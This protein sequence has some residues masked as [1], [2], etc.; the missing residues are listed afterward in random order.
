MLQADDKDGHD[1]KP[2]ITK[3]YVKSTYYSDDDDYENYEYQ[4]RDEFKKKKYS[5]LERKYQK[6][7][8]IKYDDEYL[9]SD[10][11]DG[12]LLTGSD[13][14]EKIPDYLREKNNQSNE[15][16]ED[17][18]KKYPPSL[19][20]IVQ[21]T[22]LNKIKVGTLYIITFKGG[23]LGREGDHDVVIPDINIS[24]FHLKFTY[25]EK[26]SVYQCIDLGSR[27][28][29]ILN[30]KRMSTAKQ[31]SELMD[32]VHG[33]T[34]QLSQTKLLCHIHPGNSTCGLCEPGLLMD[35][36][37]DEKSVS[38]SHKEQLKK[39]QKRYGLENDSK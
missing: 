2:K 26:K 33:S 37:N 38:L 10:I 16:Y 3:N 22:N 31:E 9:E 24:K 1:V 12:E 27:N 11:E 21:D 30:G 5:K 36:K 32:I 28:G 8:I 23:S 25:N 15:K 17:I 13:D 20:I 4:Y 19:R 35:F 6:R 29:T 34:I 18:A 7:K 39:L 14:E